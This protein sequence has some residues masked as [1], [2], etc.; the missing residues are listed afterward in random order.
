MDEIR[1]LGVRPGVALLGVLW[2]VWH[3]VLL[4][5]VTNTCAPRLLSY[6][7]SPTDPVFSFGLGLFGILILAIPAAYLFVNL[8]QSE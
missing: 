5:G 2:G 1:L 3:A 6:F 8:P 4:H 7:G